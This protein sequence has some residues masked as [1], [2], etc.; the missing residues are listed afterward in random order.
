MSS[1]PVTQI[2]KRRAPRAWFHQC[3]SVWVSIGEDIFEAR[4]V[5]VSDHGV[6]LRLAPGFAGAPVG[7][8]LHTALMAPRQSLVADGV[9]VRS[10]HSEDGCQLSVSFGKKLSKMPDLI[11]TA[12]SCNYE[13]FSACCLDVKGTQVSL[14]G[15]LSGV[16]SSDLEH[17][18]SSCRVIN[19]AGVRQVD[20]DGMSA[21]A[22]AQR[23][24]DMVV[25]GCNES[26]AAKLRSYRT[27]S[28]VGVVICTKCPSDDDEG[29]SVANTR[30]H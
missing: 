8:H 2:E 20:L 3:P 28:A 30:P 10:Q 16:I 15:W 1:A 6:A 23:R 24:F 11:G 27:Q 9:V 14:R 25:C 22:G 26:V 12:L 29:H 21:L 7:E 19:M 5:N 18:A 4:C 13:E 17:F